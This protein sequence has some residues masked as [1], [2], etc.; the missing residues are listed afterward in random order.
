[1][2]THQQIKIKNK[3]K[4]KKEKKRKKKANINFDKNQKLPLF[5]CISTLKS[6]C[7][8]PLFF[9]TI[10]YLLKNHLFCCCLPN[11]VVALS[12]L[13]CTSFTNYKERTNTATL[14]CN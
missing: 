9:T 13:S 3:I 10:K 7:L 2:K 11:H 12:L 5:N 4:K 1:M 14:F 8:M 6:T